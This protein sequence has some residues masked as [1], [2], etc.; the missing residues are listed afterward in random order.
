MLLFLFW[1]FLN[2]AVGCTP[3]AG[4]PC[5]VSC[6]PGTV[7][8]GLQGSSSCKPCEA[9]KSSSS[10]SFFTVCGV[11][12]SNCILCAE[13]TK[14][15]KAA[16][17]CSPCEVS[18]VNTTVSMCEVSGVKV[19]LCEVSALCMASLLLASNHPHSVAGMRRRPLCCYGGRGG[20]RV[21]QRARKLI[22]RVNAVRRGRGV[23]QGQSPRF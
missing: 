19:S 15:S 10:S 9:G 5:S 3:C 13:G 22:P 23:G 7:P 14:V 21:M 2:G 16:L 8:Q 12:S 20:V 4:E 11:N 1:L 6:P 18:G 17:F